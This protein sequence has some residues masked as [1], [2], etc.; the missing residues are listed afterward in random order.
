[1]RKV[2]VIEELSEKREQVIVLPPVM[3][4]KNFASIAQQTP[5]KQRLQYCDEN[6]SASE[7]LIYEE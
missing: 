5:S 7:C 6:P 4:L 2:I 3:L 1:L